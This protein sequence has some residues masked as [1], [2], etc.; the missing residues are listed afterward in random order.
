MKKLWC[1]SDSPGKTITVDGWRDLPAIGRPDR[2]ALF[3]WIM[4]SKAVWFGKYNWRRN[5]GMVKIPK[6]Q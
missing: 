5:H 4:D 6:G 1:R 3:S 2:C